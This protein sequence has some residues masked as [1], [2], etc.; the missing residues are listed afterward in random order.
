MEGTLVLSQPSFRDL[1][2]MVATIPPHWQCSL[3]TV[4]SPSA[5]QVPEGEKS[6]G[7]WGSRSSSTGTAGM[8]SGGARMV[9]RWVGDRAGLG[10]DGEGIS[11][12]P[13]GIWSLHSHIYVLCPPLS[14]SVPV[15]MQLHIFL[16]TASACG[17]FQVPTL[18]HMW[19]EGPGPP[20]LG[21]P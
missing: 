20:Q 9:P 18:V 11:R 21:R 1:I 3:M 12:G 15:Q 19:G 17:S 2:R 14:S 10:G 5:L 7:E 16:S 13:M 8:G 4:G 6:Q